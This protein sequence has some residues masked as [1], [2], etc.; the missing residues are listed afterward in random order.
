MRRR[1]LILGLGGALATP[2]AARA[3]QKAMPVIGWLH[4]GSADPFGY[5]VAEGD[6]DPVG[7]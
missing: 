2:L 1:D 6:L 5:Q 3:Q 7:V 4:F